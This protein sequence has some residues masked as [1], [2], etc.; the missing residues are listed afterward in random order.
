MVKCNPRSSNGKVRPIDRFICDVGW[1]A[2]IR[3]QIMEAFSDPAKKEITD[4]TNINGGIARC[5]G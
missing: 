4:L 5:Q 3:F 2:N 1:R